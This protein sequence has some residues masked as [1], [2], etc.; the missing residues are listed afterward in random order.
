MKSGVLWK[1]VVTA[2]GKSEYP[3]VA[4]EHHLA[5]ACAMQL[6][7]W[8]KQYD[9]IVCDNLFGDILSDVA[10]MLTDR[11][12]CCPPPRSARRCETGQ[13]KSLYE[14]CMA[15]PRDIAGAALPTRSR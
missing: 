11:S 13:R 5:D 15:R 6:V 7:R 9:V 8:P 1:Q 10:A 12:A 3:D 14:P 2:I 4:L